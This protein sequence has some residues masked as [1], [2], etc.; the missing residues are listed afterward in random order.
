MEKGILFFVKEEHFSDQRYLTGFF[1]ES[2]KLINQQNTD[3]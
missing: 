2:F 1:D 3:D